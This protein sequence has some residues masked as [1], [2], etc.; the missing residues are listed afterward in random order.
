MTT[1]TTIAPKDRTEVEFVPFGSEDKIKLSVAIVKSFVANPTKSGVMPSDRDAMKFLM[2]CRS[3]RLNPFEGDAFLLGYDTK[4][5]PQFSLITAHQAFLKRAECHPEYDGMESGVIVRM[6]DGQILDREGDFYLEGETVVGG[7]STVYFKSRKFPMK[8]RLRLRTFQ[9]PYGV[10]QTDP[11]GMICKC[12]DPET[13]VLTTHGFEKFATAEGKILQVTEQGLEPTDAVPFFQAYAGP[14]VNYRSRNGNFL[15]TTNHDMPISLNGSPETKMEAIQL[16]NLRQRDA[17]IMPLTITGSKPEYPIT[18]ATIQLAAAYIADGSDNSRSAGFSISVSRPKKV[19]FLNELGQYVSQSI[20]PEKGDQSKLANGRVI[21]TT[22]DKTAFYYSRTPEFMLLVGRKKIINHD[23]IINLSMRQA[24]LFLDTWMFFDG[25]DVASMKLGRIYASRPR[26]IKAV[27]LLAVLAGYS[28]NQPAS[29]QPDVG[30]TN[31]Y[32]A[33]T[34]RTS[35]RLSKAL[36]CLTQNPGIGVWCVTVPSGKIVVRRKGFSAVCHQ[37][38]EADSLRSAFPTMLGGMY[39]REEFDAGR[40]SEPPDMPEAKVNKPLFQ[41]KPKT[42]VTVAPASRDALAGFLKEHKM[43]FDALRLLCEEHP[44]FGSK[45]DVWTSLD[46]VS[47][48]DAKALLE[49]LTVVE[50]NVELP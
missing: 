14:M 27:E 28:V 15:V 34:D 1:S 18:D 5:G 21:T 22:A 42:E 46:D 10:W 11:G 24:R 38:A 16:L 6:E 17:A 35:V 7:W 3:R 50:G 41:K 9:K 47:D 36:L 4:E 12:F 20:K 49:S 23:A 33:I 29:R 25:A 30:K 13:E 37:C 26:H 48:E 39:L 8:K 19:R 2:L 45:I 31:Y 32:V 40:T 44:R 43:T